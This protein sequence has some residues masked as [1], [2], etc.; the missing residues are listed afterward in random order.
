MAFHPSQDLPGLPWLED[1]VQRL[2]MVPPACS[3][4]GING[5]FHNRT[6]RAD[7]S[8]AILWEFNPPPSSKG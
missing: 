7:P 8:A 2:D 4:R 1:K 3:D 6:E 5:K